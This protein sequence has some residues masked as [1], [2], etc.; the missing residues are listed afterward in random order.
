M[1]GFLAAHA[2]NAGVDAGSGSFV[3]N[4]VIELLIGQHHQADVPAS[5]RQRFQ[6]A[7]SALVKN[8]GRRQKQDNL[9]I[10]FHHLA[11]S[12]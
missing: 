12:N 7:I 10:I 5:V 4:I 2:Y 1:V 6:K 11:P 3:T 8:T 9:I